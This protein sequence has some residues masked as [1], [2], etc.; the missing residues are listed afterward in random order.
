MIY[1]DNHATT[2]CDPRVVESMLPYFSTAFGNPAS[3]IHKF[4]R[5]A[6]NAIEKARKT[7][8][9]LIGAQPREIVFTSGAT[10][11]NNIA[12]QGLVHGSKN[13]RKKIVTTAIEHK[14]I[15][16]QCKALSKQ[17]YD[18]VFL[19]VN[20]Y[21]EV[22]FEA[23]EKIIDE[24]TLLVTVQTASNE[25]G[26]IQDISNLASIAQREGAFFHTDAAQAIG[27]I[28][29]N[30]NDLGVDLL[31]I[32][33][34]KF[35]GPKGVGALFIRGGPYSM[36]IEA[37]TYG[38]EQESNLRSGTLNVPGIIGLG[39][40]C[41]LCSYELM[42]DYK[43]VSQL[44]DYLEGEL[45]ESLHVSIN[46]AFEN[47]LPNNSS[48]TI[49]GVDAEALIVNMPSLALSTGSA[50]TS[51]ALEPSHVLQAIGMSRDL[52]NNTF[53]IGLGRFNTQK[54]IEQAADIIIRTAT[55]LLRLESKRH[56]T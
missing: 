42:K 53:R 46:G 34:H 20:R 4:G 18:I 15:L 47:R 31:S 35:Y 14:A 36:P 28:V 52:A 43:H 9:L 17:G 19:P 51:G 12:I 38:G 5:D 27:K 8:S 40:A 2:P 10:E 23:A 1:L 21:G 29:L 56:K 45:K 32:S 41:E 11:S 44:R 37:L 24:K 50:C 16:N 22:E 26:T 3:T 25:I 13:N 33:A 7:V 39:K 6:D 49:N 30:V 48:I 54:E 55:E